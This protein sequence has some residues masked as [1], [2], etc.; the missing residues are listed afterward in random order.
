MKI[1]NFKGF[2]S[3][4]YKK[5]FL[6]PMILL[7]LGI[8]VIANTYSKEGDFIRKDVT[9][10]GGIVATISTD[11]DS[12]S[13]ES[14]L[15]EEFPEADLFVRSLVEFGSDEQ[16]GLIVEASDIDADD[17]QGA[18][19]DHLGIE[20]NEDNYS[21]EEAGSSLSEGFYRQMMKALII[22]FILMAIA[23]F[24]TF[25]SLVPSAAVIGAAITDI[26][27]TVGF[28]DLIGMKV[29]TAGIAALLMLIGY[30]VDTDILLSTKVL[31]RKEG[32]IV[33]RIFDSMKTGLTMTLTT[34]IALSAGY[35]VTSN[36]V[37]KQMF[38]IIVF[39]LLVDILSTYCQNAG[40]LMWYTKRK[41]NA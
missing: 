30:S 35:F 24:A 19:E 10:K 12:A 37:L 32:S 21:V 3:K 5:L 25:R 41:E 16:I 15:V 29:G 4:N 36:L 9:L 8:L 17:L 22:A 26:I 23:V 20:L 40:I 27:V 7:V 14:Y 11:A 38:L 39:G 33:D 28:I 13:L 6:I 1:D 2:Y 34:I 31:K 18:I